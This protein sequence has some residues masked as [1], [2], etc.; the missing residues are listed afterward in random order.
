[1][2]LAF[3][4]QLAEGERTEIAVNIRTDGGMTNAISQGKTRHDNRRLYV[5]G[6]ECAWLLSNLLLHNLLLEKIEQLKL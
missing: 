5:E 4:L 6:I 3:S 1:M 2:Q